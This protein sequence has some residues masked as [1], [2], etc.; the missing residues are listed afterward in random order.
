[1]L[2]RVGM[3]ETAVDDPVDHCFRA[4]Y[5][6]KPLTIDAPWNVPRF[7]ALSLLER[8]LS[9]SVGQF[10]VTHLHDWSLWRSGLSKMQGWNG[11]SSHLNKIFY[12]GMRQTRSLVLLG[13]DGDRRRGGLGRIG[14]DGE[15]AGAG[16]ARLPLRADR[17]AKRTQGAVAE[18]GAKAGPRTA[19]CAAFM[20]IL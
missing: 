18:G 8:T 19:V 7:R 9:F 10:W 6:K 2:H 15:H 1:M 16:V 17:A 13:G 4:H 20:I 5:A 3:L 14:G 12:Y 11:K